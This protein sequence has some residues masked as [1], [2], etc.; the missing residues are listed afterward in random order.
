MKVQLKPDPDD[1]LVLVMYSTAADGQIFAPSAAQS[2]VGQEVPISIGDDEPDL[3]GTIIAAEVVDG[4]KAL[5]L[6]V[7]VSNIPLKL[8]KM[9]ENRPNMH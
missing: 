6:D 8:R 5:Q 7:E 1:G 2:V 4:G 9:L 3:L